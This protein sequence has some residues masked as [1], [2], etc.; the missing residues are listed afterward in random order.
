MAAIKRL[1]DQIRKANDPLT[2][3]EKWDM[4][5]SG[6]AA[7]ISRESAPPYHTEWSTL[8][9]WGDTKDSLK[10]VELEQRKAEVIQ[11]AEAALDTSMLGESEAA[12]A[13]LKKLE[14]AVA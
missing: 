9:N 12:L 13:A 4:V 5:R 7:L 6:T 2:S 3:Q 8:F 1:D 14:G 10:I 11:L